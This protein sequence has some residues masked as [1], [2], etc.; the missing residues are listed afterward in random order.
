MTVECSVRDEKYRKM[1]K[2][3]ITIKW[4]FIFSIAVFCMTRALIV[5]SDKMESVFLESFT[6]LRRT[7]WIS[8][9]TCVPR[10]VTNDRVL[11]EI[12]RYSDSRRMCVRFNAVRINDGC[13]Y[14]D[15]RKP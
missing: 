5:L 8:H 6:I 4:V 12:F 2:I 9:I 13:K 1:L 14:T 15:L 10:L 3:P 11:R 7:T